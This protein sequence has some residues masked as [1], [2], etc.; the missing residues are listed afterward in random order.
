MGAG[1]G[2]VALDD[3]VLGRS[4]LTQAC[5]QMLG[6]LGT[7]GVGDPDDI[8]AGVFNILLVHLGEPLDGSASAAL[9]FDA[10]YLALLVADEQRLYLQ[11]R[12]CQRN[13]V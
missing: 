13:G 9:F 12:A 2:L 3:N 5:G 7:V 11:N 10:D 4:D 6:I 1:H 8:L